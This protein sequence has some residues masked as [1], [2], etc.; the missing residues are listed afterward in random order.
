MNGTGSLVPLLG[1]APSL[2]TIRRFRR[3]AENLQHSI[4]GSDLRGR[5]AAGLKPLPEVL[6]LNVVFDFGL[7][8]L[9]NLYHDSR[10]AFSELRNP[11]VCVEGSQTARHRFVERLS[12]YL[13]GMLHAFEVSARDPAVFE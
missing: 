11:G 10:Q 7:H 4:L 5:P 1:R 3:S 8:G 13:D 6:H 2:L 12:G 9:P